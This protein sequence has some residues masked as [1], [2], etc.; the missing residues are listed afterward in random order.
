GDGADNDFGA[1]L[2]SDRQDI[3][4]VSSKTVVNRLHARIVLADLAFEEHLHATPLLA[5]RHT[6]VEARKN[7]LEQLTCATSLQDETAAD[8]NHSRSFRTKNGPNAVQTDDLIIPHIENP[9]VAG[10]T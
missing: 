1:F 6:F 2:V 5:T 3:G 7:A 9:D 8:K 4:K 10:K